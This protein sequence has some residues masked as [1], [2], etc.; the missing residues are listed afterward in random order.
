M[1]EDV[2]DVLKT[3]MVLQLVWWFS[4]IQSCYPQDKFFVG[5]RIVFL[6]DPLLQRWR[7]AH[8]VLNLWCFA[9]VDSLEKT[10]LHSEDVWKRVADFVSRRK[11]AVSWVQRQIKHVMS[12]SR[13]WICYSTP[14]QVRLLW[15]IFCWFLYQ[16]FIKLVSNLWLWVPHDLDVWVIFLSALLKPC[17]IR[18]ALSTISVDRWTQRLPCMKPEVVRKQPLTWGTREAEYLLIFIV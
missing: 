13:S 15:D 9:C 5:L 3:K 2:L 6:F 4:A 14:R 17:W 1:T 18:P 7:L 12:A 10:S 16:H 8:S 11:W